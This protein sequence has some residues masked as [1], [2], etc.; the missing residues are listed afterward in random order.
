[1]KVIEG[2]KS[3]FKQHMEKITSSFKVGIEIVE[4]KIKFTNKIW[5]IKY[6]K[7]INNNKCLLKV[8]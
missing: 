1:M 8:Y 7:L 6:L 3:S 5:Y 4:D 2:K